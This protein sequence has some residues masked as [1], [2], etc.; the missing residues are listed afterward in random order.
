LGVLQVELELRL[1]FLLEVDFPA[2]LAA[3]PRAV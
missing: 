2:N 1:E 3:V